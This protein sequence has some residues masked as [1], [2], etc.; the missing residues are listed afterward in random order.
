MR[1]QS[2]DSKMPFK[3]CGPRAG[4]KVP[5]GLTI[6]GGAILTFWVPTC[7]FSG[8]ASNLLPLFFMSL[9]YLLGLPI[10]LW[11]YRQK[12]DHQRIVLPLQRKPPAATS[13]DERDKEK[14]A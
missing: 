12:V 14:A 1:V 11:L 7:V 2:F 9:A 3:F 13:V 4:D 10:G 5:G 8:V 6:I